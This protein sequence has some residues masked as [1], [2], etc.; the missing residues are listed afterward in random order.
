MKKIIKLFLLSSMIS[1]NVAFA[2][3]DKHIQKNFLLP[4]DQISN[5]ALK[6]VSWN[7]FVNKKPDGRYSGT[8][9]IVPFYQKSTAK[10]SLGHYFG[11]VNDVDKSKAPVYENVIGAKQEHGNDKDYLLL[12]GDIIHNNADATGAG[13]LVGKFNF[14]PYQEIWGARLDWHQDLDELINGLFFEIS[15]VPVSVKNNMNLTDIGTQHVQ[16]VNGVDVTFRDYFLGNI[17]NSNES[18]IQEELKYSR[19][20]GSH[21]TGGFADVEF[22]LGYHL[23]YKPHF[24]L[25][26]EGK[27]LVPT[28]NQPKAID[29]FEPIY[30]SA[31][32]WAIGGAIDTDLIFWKTKMDEKHILLH[33]VADYKYYFKAAEKRTPTFKNTAG[34]SKL[35]HIYMLGGQTGY[36]KVFPLANVLTQDL[37]IE[38]GSQFELLASLNFKWNRWF[39]DLGYNLFSRESEAV[40]F[41]HAWNNYQY[42]VA[43]YDYDTHTHD[44]DALDT[45]A[46]HN[47]GVRD[48]FAAIKDSDID[49]DSV[50]QPSQLT[51]TFY[52]GFAYECKRFKYPVMF[53]LGGHYE[54]ASSNASLENWGLYL[55]GSLA[56]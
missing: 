7:Y 36:R 27:V 4:R 26:F 32:H 37:Y 45:N 12:P 25:S 14:R 54:I 56:Y 40:E 52:A 44:F 53:G 55:K 5:L 24:R 47:Y 43:K 29:R 18:N 21:T 2:I 48:G 20:G 33:L 9:Q 19:M 10:N 13:L 15:T 11:F 42:A 49:L 34:V 8:F 23:F 22:D 31:D 3:S 50:K 16:A 35:E 46:A 39:L 17:S 38:P 6:D 1:A 30:G 28:G 51:H 41:K